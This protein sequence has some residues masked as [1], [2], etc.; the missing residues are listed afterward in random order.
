VASLLSLHS[1]SW[2]ALVCLESP[3]PISR[4]IS[5]LKAAG[6]SF[7]ELLSVGM[8]R[9]AKNLTWE[10]VLGDDTITSFEHPL[11]EMTMDKGTFYETFRAVCDMLDGSDMSSFVDF[12]FERS[13]V[14]EQ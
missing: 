7:Q 6:Y 1:A 3:G 11:T 5:V 13:P 9:L 10:T 2:E 8:E 12:F 14:Q 4:R